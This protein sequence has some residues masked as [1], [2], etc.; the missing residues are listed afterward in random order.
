[1]P[2]Y[3]R[4]RSSKEIIAFLIAKGFRLTNTLGDD[5]VYTKDGWFLTC[6]VT[7]GKKATPIGTMQQI[8]RCSGYSS[9]EW[10]KWWKEND[11]GE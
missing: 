5:E 10:I 3:L 2:R 4:N 6:K 1:M 7:E 11:F 9:K 8:K